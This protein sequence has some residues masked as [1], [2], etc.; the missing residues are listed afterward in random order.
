MNVFYILIK[1]HT[2]MYSHGIGVI[3][4]KRRSYKEEVSDIKKE[5]DK[6]INN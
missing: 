2:E 5:K 1:T 3:E 4:L 6:D